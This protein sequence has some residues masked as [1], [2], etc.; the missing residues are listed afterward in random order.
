VNYVIENR[1]RVYEDVSDAVEYFYSIDLFF[2]L[3]L[4]KRLLGLKIN[5]SKTKPL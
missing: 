2:M 4:E 5:Q 3:K 1:P